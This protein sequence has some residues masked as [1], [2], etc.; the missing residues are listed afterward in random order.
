MS[1]MPRKLPDDRGIARFCFVPIPAGRLSQNRSSKTLD[2][3]SAPL[4]SG[5]GRLG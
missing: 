5:S 2:L 4:L 3:K 1:G